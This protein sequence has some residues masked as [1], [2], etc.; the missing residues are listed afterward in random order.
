ML[1]SRLETGLLGIKV[2]NY[3]HNH[4]TTQIVREENNGLLSRK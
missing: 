3:I 4:Y 1:N 2:L